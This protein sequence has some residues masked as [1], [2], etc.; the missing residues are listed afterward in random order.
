MTILAYYE[1]DGLLEI[2]HFHFIGLFTEQEPGLSERYLELVS[3]EYI[4]CCFRW[5]PVYHQEI[6]IRNDRSIEHALALRG[7]CRTK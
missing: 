6:V 5:S 3:L 4:L 1:I 2:L 7:G